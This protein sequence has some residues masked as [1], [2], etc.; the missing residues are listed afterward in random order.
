[1]EGE[2]TEASKFGFKMILDVIIEVL[3]M[4]Q[5]LFYGSIISCHVEPF[6]SLCCHVGIKIWI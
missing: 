5:C 4:S 2:G 1:V 3:L 6:L